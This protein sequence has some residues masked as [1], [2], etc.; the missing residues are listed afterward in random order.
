M[1]T[2]WQRRSVA[3]SCIKW[4]TEIPQ[5]VTAC[6]VPWGTHPLQPYQKRASLRAAQIETIL[7]GLKNQLANCDIPNENS[8]G[9]IQTDQINWTAALDT[10]SRFC[11]ERVMHFSTLNNKAHCTPGILRVPLVAQFMYVTRIHR[12]QPCWKWAN[13]ITEEYFR[14]KYN[15]FTK[16]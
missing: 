10:D 12:P 11:C 16:I 13:V 7:P 6:A 1:L 4:Q 15:G 3:L 2:I 8:H 14:Y 9:P 5:T